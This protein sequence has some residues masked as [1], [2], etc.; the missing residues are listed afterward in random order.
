MSLRGSLTYGLAKVLTSIL[1]P[2]VGKSP[3]CSHS[4]QGSVEQANKVT[5]QLGEW[6]S[7]YDVT[8]LFTSVPVDPAL[9]IIKGLLEKGNIL[10][11]RTILPVKDI[12]LLLQFC[13]HNTYFSFQAK[14]YKQVEGAIMGSPVS[15]I[16]AN[17]Y[18][19]YF[20]PEASKN[21]ICCPGYGWGMW[22]TLLSSKKEEHKQNFLEHIN[23]V[24]TAIK[25]TMED[26]KEDGAIPFQDTIVKP[27]ADN[28]LS[29]TEYRKPT[30][31]GQYMQGDSHLHLLDKYSAI[32]SLTHLDCDEEY[33][34]ETS[35][36][37]FGER[38]KEHL[39]DHSPIHDCSNTT[40]HITTQDNLQIIGREDHGTARTIKE[41]IYIRVNNPTLNRNIGKFN[42]HHIWDRV[43]LNTPGL[44]ANRQG[45]S[46]TSIIHSQ[47][48]SPNT[49]MYNSQVFGACLDHT[50]VWV[51]T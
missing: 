9:H 45:Q 2:L 48:P 21:A 6:L 44:K 37:T 4:A 42:L 7:S 31:T 14:F 25:L 41:S 22:M 28:T 32:N 47:F 5:L 24:D 20:E 51:C 15:P 46:T 18:M 43:L 49:P 33:I 3:H 13:L 38:F 12:I 36:R 29:I 39:K 40:G 16:V 10:K 50:L 30:H 11:E 35:R 23:S 8:A 17:P 34:G 1:K 27:E 26:T 19:E